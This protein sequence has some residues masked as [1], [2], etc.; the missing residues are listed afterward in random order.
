MKKN[1]KDKKILD[2]CCGGRMFWFDKNN[3]KVLFIDNRNEEHVLCDGRKYNITPDIVMDFRKLE[4]KDESFKLVVFDPPH[5]IN[6]GE[7]SWMAKK[8][9]VL[10]ENWKKD[11]SKGFSECW[12][13]LEKNGI[14]I[15]KWS[16]RDIKIR[17]I[18]ELFT[19]K[20]LFGHTTGK[21]GH[22][23]WMCFIKI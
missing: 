14:L 17:T 15:F 22:V 6:L 9:G 18:L 12:R 19:E 11:L 13:V 2:A 21:C 4:F 20:P 10:G 3:K 16:E 1:V 8:Y 23:K 7:N 5:L